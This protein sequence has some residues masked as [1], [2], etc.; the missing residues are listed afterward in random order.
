MLDEVPGHTP[1][2]DSVDSLTEYMGETT[3]KGMLERMQL[4]RREDRMVREALQREIEMYP[5]R[6]KV[7]TIHEAKGREAPAVLLAAG[8]P[9]RLEDRW[10]RDEEFREEERR[11]YYVAASRASE[12]LAVA[13]DFCGGS[14]MP[15]FDGGIPRADESEVV[16]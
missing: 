14:T 11:L 15:L 8:Y 2:P 3:A 1:A 6:I 13:Y 16:A 7:G 12:T 9:S 10:D 4:S 5:S